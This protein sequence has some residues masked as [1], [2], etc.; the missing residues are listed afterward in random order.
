MS[1]RVADV[2]IETLQ[3]AGVKN[4]YGIV[5]D[6]LNRIAHA[7]ERSE[8]DWVH[9]RHEE[10]GAF[11]AQAEAQLTGRL[12][13]CAGSC[14][15]GG[16]HFINGLYE[17]NRNRAPVIVIATQIIRQDIGFESIQE[18]DFKE[19]FK[20]CSVFCEMILTPEQA[21]RKTVAA[22]QAAL[23]R[24]GVAVLVV[25]TDIANAAAH[26]ELPYAVHASRP[27]IRPS[28]VDLDAI[29]AVLNRSESIAIYAGAGCAG[30]HDE[31]VATASRLKAPMAHTSR[32]K[33]FLEYDNPYNVGMTGI[34]G[35]P[36]AY[37][38]VLDCDVLLLLGADFAWPQFYPNKATILQIDEDPTHIGR[39]HPVAIG[40][41]GDIKTTLQALLPRLQQHEDNA[42]LAGHVQRHEKDVAEA[43]AEKPS[44]SDAISGTYLTKVINQHAA[45]DALFAADDGTALVWMLRHIETGGG[46]R[47][48]GSL[49]HGT[50]ASGM[51]SA[52]GLQKC[53]PGRQVIC[54][55]GDGGFAMLLGDLMTT[56]QENLPIKIAVY[57]NSKLGFIDIEQKAAGMIPVYTDL[58]NPNFGDV[59]KAMGLWGHQVTKAGDLEESV[60]TWLAQPGPAVLDVKVKPMQL[61]T[62]PSPFVSS[63]A[64]VGMA[65]Y[66][67][68]AMLHGKGHD[69]WEMLVENIS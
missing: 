30:A 42:F 48:F 13:A 43:K 59:A 11:A 65:V 29:A 26:D 45:R 35:G 60:R 46:R 49:L 33:D 36:A 64:V 20:G 10:A 3:A 22:C 47:T 44:G 52:L 17:A 27:L 25:P 37:R 31:V 12:T 6:T 58:K 39:R 14:G 28:D 67:A 61:V 40:A 9:M 62:P 19:V 57:D 53:Q 55:A 34:I 66:T 69:V 8:I 5:G 16:L 32:G 68:K 56:V 51:P 2:L 38:A 21:R 4:C 24:R 23:T 1:K 15:P 7:I 18:V 54:L 41:V 63:E 50:M